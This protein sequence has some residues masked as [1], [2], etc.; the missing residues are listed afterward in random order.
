MSVPWGGV[1]PCFQNCNAQDREIGSEVSTRI[2]ATASRI[3]G[4]LP[5][6]KPS[7]WALKARP[8]STHPIQSP[9]SPFDP[10][11]SLPAVPRWYSLFLWVE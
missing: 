6:K 10:Q 5:L 4:H 9:A 11:F 2:A 3:K 1:P 7:A 8:S